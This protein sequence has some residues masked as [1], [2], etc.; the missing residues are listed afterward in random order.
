MRKLIVNNFSTLDGYYEGKDR[1]I[2]SLYE[3]YHPSYEGEDSF[4]HYNAERLRSADML[5]LSHSAF[6][7][8]RDYWPKVAANPA[9]TAIRHELARLMSDTPKLVVSDRLG[10]A[11]LA[12]WENTQVIGRADAHRQIAALKQQGDGDILVLMSRMLWNDLLA[13]GL[14][15]ELH[16]TYFPLIAG[17]GTPIFDGR[18]PVALRLLHTRTWPG[19]GN[20]LTCYEVS[21]TPN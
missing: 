12:P 5:L 9:A 17:A 1:D 11:D 21:S 3:H 19:S 14:V 13:H 8:N 2:I 10:Q 4:D 18:P 16:L 20:V 15:D 7:G 6:L